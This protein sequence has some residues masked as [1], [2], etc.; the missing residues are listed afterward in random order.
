L[1]VAQRGAA[2][3]SSPPAPRA[4]LSS[5]SASTSTSIGG[6]RAVAGILKHW[7]LLAVDDETTAG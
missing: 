3:L 4:P 6:E 5:P 1:V 7:N 2:L